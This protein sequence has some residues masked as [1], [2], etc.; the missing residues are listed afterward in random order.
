MLV[1]W[2]GKALL[3]PVSSFLG[4]GK[5][6]SQPLKLTATLLGILTALCFVASGWVKEWHGTVKQQ[7]AA[8]TS[9]APR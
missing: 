5:E 6:H 2:L 9:E 4:Q 7:Q 8:V 3:A 1:A